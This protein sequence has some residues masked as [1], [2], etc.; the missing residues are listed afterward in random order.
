MYPRDQFGCVEI[1]ISEIRERSNEIGP[2][3]N[4]KTKDFHFP[5]EDT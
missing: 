2:V 4:P 3:L 5:W 1:S